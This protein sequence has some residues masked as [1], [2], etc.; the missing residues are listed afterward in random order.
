MH[1]DDFDR[2]RG[3]DDA[4]DPL[5]EPLREYEPDNRVAWIGL[6]VLLVVVAG[7]LWWWRPQST[8]SPA[9]AVGQL[10]TEEV[11]EPSIRAQ[12]SGLGVGGPDPDLP[13]LG[14]MDRYVRPLLA[15]LSSRPEL[16]ALL[17]TD[18]LVRRFV[19]SVESI[20]RGVSPAGQV[21][22]VAPRG[23]FTVRQQGADYVA[24]PASFA[25]YDGLVALVDDMDPRALARLYGRLKPRFDEA[26]DELGVPGTFD[27]TIT[28]AIRHLLETP[29]PPPQP[30][31]RQATGTNYAY[32]DPQLE[33]LSEA[34][35]HVLRLGPE[36]AAR[37][38]ARLREF[39]VA[40]GIPD[41]QL[42][43]AP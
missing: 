17:A 43:G 8:Q 32:L 7:G 40:L 26:H 16:A 36:R 23:P 12:A 9:E 34:Q 6:I 29:V 1:M 19:V 10:P 11:V 3:R 25:R 41:G 20:A 14:E 42:P 22:A 13:A 33:S 15:A 2:L 18:G 38:K 4:R 27:E 5:E 24:D 28:R 31:L 35:R 37:V 21:R 30:R 39:G